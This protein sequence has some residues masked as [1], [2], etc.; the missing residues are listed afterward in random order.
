MGVVLK[1]SIWNT[2]VTYIGFGLGAINTLF[3]YTQILS[4]E[5]YGL[6]TFILATA[7]VFMPLMAMGIQNTLVKFHSQ[8]SAKSHNGFFTMMLCYPLLVMT[9]LAVILLLFETQLKAYVSKENSIAGAYLWY[10]YWVGV[11]MAYFE[12]FFSWS[13]VH[14]KSIYGNILK[15]IFSR[16]C[17]LLL[18]VALYFQQLSVALFFKFLV[19]VYILRMLL[20]MF[21]A[22]RLYR[23]KINF[24]FPKE[25]NEILKYSWLMILGGSAAVIILEIDKFMINQ[26][27]PLE[28][29]AYYGVAVYIAMVIIVPS[30][31]MHQITY[32][33]TAKLLSTNNFFELDNLYKK[34]SLTLFMASGILFLLIILNLSDLYT[35]LP[36][37]YRQGFTIVLFIGLAKV[38]DSLLGNI[39]SIL[40]NSKYYTTILG[41]GF[42]LALVTI[43][44][45]SIFIPWIGIDGAALASFIAIFIFNLIKMSF[46][47]LKFGLLPFTKGTVKVLG[48]LLFLGVLFYAIPFYFHPIINIL[49]K[50][51][52]LMVMYLGILYRLAISDD[53][54]GVLDTILKRKTP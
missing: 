7:T 29:V 46:V 35:L 14:L 42:L 38:F 5:Q 45:N 31:A 24:K 53:V 50:S 21:S 17:I 44:L 22:F 34:S 33:L 36:E 51:L 30:R 1:Q 28:N 52:L 12:V 16:A 41:L 26:Y 39:N 3:L 19:G 13:K 32:P 18:L 49:I 54:N 6:V 10:I 8:Q 9:A 11:A 27:I 47:K 37:D 2:L 25:R 15:E 4:A 20:M 43:V 48:L 23:P 40:Y